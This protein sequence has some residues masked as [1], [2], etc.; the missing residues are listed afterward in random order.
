M[1]VR[2]ARFLHL[3][4]TEPKDGGAADAE[5]DDDEEEKDYYFDS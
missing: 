1:N 3:S 2:L 4:S 5:D